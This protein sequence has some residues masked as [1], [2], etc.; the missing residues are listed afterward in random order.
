MSKTRASVGLPVAL[1]ALFLASPG[2]AGD[3]CTE[4]G[5]PATTVPQF[6][7][8]IP[9]QSIWPLDGTGAVLFKPASEI[10]PRRDST[11]YITQ[12]IPGNQSGHE[13]FQ[14]VAAVE[15]DDNWVY[16]AYNAGLQIWDLRS[17][18]ADPDRELFR[19]GWL[20]QFEFFP[21]P[22]EGDTYITAIDVIQGAG[23]NVF[24]ALSGELGHG[25]SFWRFNTA[26][27]VLTQI[28]QETGRCCAG[29]A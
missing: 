9:G 26:T 27:Q 6:R 23:N 13:L 4:E 1:L 2:F 25:V 20:G 10:P 28:F 14:D 7:T 16:V 24:I 3:I 22:G 8:E 5:S 15:G 17:D 11:S 18:P 19:D 12:T 29:S 21:P